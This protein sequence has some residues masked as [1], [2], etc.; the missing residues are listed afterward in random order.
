M[1]GTETRNGVM[2]SGNHK[3]F[4]DSDPHKSQQEVAG[5]KPGEGDR[6]KMVESYEAQ[7]FILRKQ[8]N[9]DF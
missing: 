3:Q 6:D 1:K 8:R 9:K 4:V 5:N 7:I 2:V